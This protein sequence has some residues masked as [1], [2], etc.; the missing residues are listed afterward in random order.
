MKVLWFEVTEPAAYGNGKLVIGGWQ[1]SLEFVV[2]QSNDI[3]LYIAF[4]SKDSDEIRVIDG[5]TYIPIKC[6][7]SILERFSRRFSWKIYSQKLIKECVDIVSKVNPD[8]IHVFGNEWPF[9]LVANHVSQPVVIHIQGSIVPYYNARYA[10]GYNLLTELIYNGLH[11]RR[12]LGAILNQLNWKSRLR[13]E[14]KVWNSVHNYMGRTVWDKALANVLAPGSSYFHVEEAIRPNF[15][16]TNDIWHLS[17]SSKIR[18]V[19]TGCSSFLKGVDVILKTAHVLKERGVDFEWIIAGYMPK[20]LKDI[21]ERKEGLRFED[22]NVKI[23]GFVNPA[24]LQEILC[25]STMYVHAAYI[26]NSP[27][28]ICEAQLLGVPIISTMVGGISSLIKYGEEGELLPTN[29]PWLM[30][31]AIIRLS[32]D[33]ERMFQYSQRGREHALQRHNPTNILNQLLNCYHAVLGSV[34]Y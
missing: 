8:L 28:S 24:R 1:D 14:K 33:K 17:E 9:G 7:Y 19:S 11:F 2:R 30:A 10:P 23:L 27:N 21:V 31:D 29:D 13:M 18:I 22:N 34:K 3:E 32:N 25:N 26:E 15:L 4:E 12:S 16:Q 20:G 5:V 6:K